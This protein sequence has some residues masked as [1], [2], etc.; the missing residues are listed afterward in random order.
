MTKEEIRNNLL[1]KLKDIL[2]EQPKGYSQMTTMVDSIREY[3]KQEDIPAHE[4][5]K[6][7]NDV[8]EIVNEWYRAGVIYFGKPDDPSAS[9][10]WFTVTKFGRECLET[11]NLLPYDPESYVQELQQQ[12]PLLD[13]IT[14]IYIRES[15]SAYNS[16]RLLSCTITLGVAS[17]NIIIDL[18]DSFVGAIKDEGTK[19]RLIKKMK[20]LSISAKYKVFRLELKNY[21]KVL[22]EDLVKEL[23]TYLDQIF[24]FIRIN[25]NQAGHP[26][27]KAVSKKVA[28]SNLQI[29]AEY[30]LVVSK[31]NDY[32]IHN[33]I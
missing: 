17:E 1:Q 23:E 16:E 28:Y 31:L 10:P 3:I 24:N 30:S 5:W 32:L 21:K 19:K 4:H 15:I 20:K 6:L 26:T 29:F 13:D 27:G 9:S 12:N 8:F 33:K 25:R 18:I 22:P 7:H 11:G 2:E 14:L